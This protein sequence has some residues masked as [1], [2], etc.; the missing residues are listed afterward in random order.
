MSREGNGRNRTNSLA[1]TGE[2]KTGKAEIF[3]ATE[4][5]DHK[6]K[7]IFLP[8]SDETDFDDFKPL[9]RGQQGKVYGARIYFTNRLGE[10]EYRDCVLKVT[11]KKKSV[12]SAPHA[13]LHKHFR[14]TEAHQSSTDH[15]IVKAIYEVER[16]AEMEKVLV[17]PYCEMFLDGLCKQLPGLA[18]THQ[19][20][21]EASLLHVMLDL[22][23]AVDHMHRHGFI[24]GDIKPDNIAYYRG[25][26]C[27]ID[28]DCAVEIN[29]SDPAFAGSPLYMHP[30]GFIDSKYRS[31]PCNDIYALGQVLK[32]LLLKPLSHDD[33]NIG[34]FITDKKTAYLKAAKKEDIRKKQ[35]GQLPSLSLGKALAELPAAASIVEKLTV[36]A[37]HMTNLLPEHQPTVTELEVC[38]E[39]LIAQLLGK[40]EENSPE[41]QL[42]KGLH[43]FYD[44]LKK[45][46]FF[47]DEPSTPGIARCLSTL[48]LFSE[49]S[50]RSDSPSLR[51]SS[52]ASTDSLAS[53]TFSNPS[54]SPTHPS[55]PAENAPLRRR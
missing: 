4:D 7:R 9:G 14:I 28:L 13:P 53:S 19:T 36:I 22:L 3:L 20:H 35:P 15:N 18:A 42:E 2:L 40:T 55:S 41:E 31:N 29:K 21:Y 16:E 26:W 43:D 44:S 38:F 12:S 27:L 34:D 46:G 52:Q 47:F 30:I 1:I 45:G 33:D 24:H 32:Q 11:S 5:P 23:R 48:S 49:Y 50:H 39:E 37:Q 10:E 6:T 17:L 51:K 25:H 8:F 54:D